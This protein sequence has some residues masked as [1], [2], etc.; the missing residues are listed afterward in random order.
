MKYLTDL[1]KRDKSKS[2]MLLLK[3]QNQERTT[4]PSLINQI[5]SANTKK[6]EIDNEIENIHKEDEKYTTDSSTTHASPITGYTEE[7]PEPPKR[8]FI[9]VKKQP[10]P[11]K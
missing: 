11:R 8:K 4:R 10:R 3:N 5:I 7:T 1:G 6:Y 2:E 9:Y